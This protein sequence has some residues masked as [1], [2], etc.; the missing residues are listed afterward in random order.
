MFRK[1]LIANRGEIAVRV[2]RACK[3]MG[4][5]TVAVYSEADRNLLHVRLADESICIGPAPAG[6][7]YLNLPNIISA[8]LVSG[9][10]AI[11]PGYGF[12]AESM[13][14][15]E[16]CASH[17]LQFIGPSVE[18]IAALGD[19]ASA[20]NLARRLH[21]PVIPGTSVLRSVSE[22]LK[23]AE[24]IGYPVMIKAVGGGGGK[25][26]R[27]AFSV[28]EL[29]KNIP[30][31]QA[32]A[33]AAFG[34]DRIYLEKLLV[35]PRHI[36]V[37]ILGDSFGNVLA[38]GEREC[39]LQRHHQKILEE[40]PSVLVTPSIRKKIQ[41]FAV[42]IAK[43][44]NYTGVG[45]IEFLRDR[46]GQFYF[47]EANARIQVEH[48]VTEMVTGLDLICEQ[49][50]VGQGKKL[51][52]SQGEVEIRGHAIECRINAEDP[53]TFAPCIGVVDALHWPGGPGIRVDSYLCQGDKV[54][55][56]YDSLLGKVIAWGSDRKT[57][58][59]RMRVALDECVVGGI[60][61]NLPLHRRL[62]RHPAVNE[63]N[64]HVAL[65]ES[66]LSEKVL[67]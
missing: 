2:I 11:H 23:S 56:F 8:A 66:L 53:E 47:I 19:K 14:F 43:G 64:L 34:D 10:D 1:I 40:A 37:Q 33:D 62:L 36:E 20:R 61:T 17:K 5:S 13:Q 18:A 30:F 46:D 6:K 45:T 58:L 57:A 60:K 35:Q 38:L 3:Q 28:A 49:I 48:P 39:S 22:A 25:G 63:G 54:T 29:E 7:S 52:F 50:Q 42:K 41:D 65:V 44:V 67:I 51:S 32:E 24:E 59:T 31:A 16:I 27:P 21:V 9:A 15:A 4:I 26:M 12:L 55:P